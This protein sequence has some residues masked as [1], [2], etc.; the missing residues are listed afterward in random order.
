MAGPVTFTINYTCSP[1]AVNGILYYAHVQPDGIL[2]SFQQATA[3][4]TFNI[5]TNGGTVLNQTLTGVYGN[6]SDFDYNTAYVFKILQFCS[7]G[8]TEYS[9]PTDPI[10]EANCDPTILSFAS[11]N[12]YIDSSYFFNVGITQQA[13]FTTS[14][15]AGFFLE[16]FDITANPDISLGG[17][18][19]SY[20]DVVANSNNGFYAFTV[21]ADDLAQPIIQSA[22]AYQAVLTILVATGIDPLTGEIIIEEFPCDI[23]TANTLECRTYKIYTGEF[24]GLEWTDCNGVKRSCFSDTPAPQSDNTG[25]NILNSFYVCSRTVPFGYAC[26]QSAPGVF[27]KSAPYY[28]SPTTGNIMYITNPILPGQIPLAPINRGAV[29]ESYNTLGCDS[30]NNGDLPTIIFD[31]TGI[32]FTCDVSAC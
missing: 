21:T 10:F 20:N 3:Y 16:I 23:E 24:W 25:N 11:S 5:A 13:N 14:S 15:I 8:T 31:T 28:I 26:V 17:V 1:D 9:D 12:T 2:S 27:V 30:I 18:N 19:I 29:V 6:G 4:G 7:G 22:N 32:T